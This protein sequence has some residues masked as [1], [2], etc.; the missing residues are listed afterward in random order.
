MLGFII[1]NSKLGVFDKLNWQFIWTKTFVI[2]FQGDLIFFYYY[3]ILV[4]FLN[5]TGLLKKF[6]IFE[7]I[8]IEL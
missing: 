8:I 4:F 2:E 5:T 1:W 7:A 3:W 6:A